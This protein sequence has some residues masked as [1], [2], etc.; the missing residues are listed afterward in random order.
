MKRDTLC[1]AIAARRLIE[2]RYDG[3][4]RVVEPYT[5]GILTTGNVA[6][7]AWHVRGFSESRAVPKWR[8]YTLDKMG[9]ITVLDEVFEGPR[10][11]YN[12]RDSRMKRIYCTF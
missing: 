11:G 2:F 8:L 7:S 4:V 9:S 5:V 12:P 10:R 3:M 1:E 6:L